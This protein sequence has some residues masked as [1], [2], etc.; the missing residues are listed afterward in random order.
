MIVAPQEF[1]ITTGSCNVLLGSGISASGATVCNEVTIGTTL[2]KARFQ[3]AASAWS[4]VSDARQK[5]NI[6]ALP[7]G[8][9]FINDLQPRKFSWIHTQTEQGGFVAQEVDEVVAKHDADY[10]NLVNKDD[11]NSWMLAQTN[12]IPVLVKAVQELDAE[13]KSLKQEFNDYRST[14]P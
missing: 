2:A 4:F 11:D 14:H 3:G 6:T 10:L 9:D 7:V 1:V 13:L 5:E 12:L 8:R